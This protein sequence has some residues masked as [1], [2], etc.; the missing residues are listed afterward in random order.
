M[1]WYLLRAAACACAAGVAGLLVRHSLAP[2]FV[3]QSLRGSAV[4]VVAVTA[5]FAVVFLALASVARIASLNDF[6]ALRPRRAA[7]G[8][9]SS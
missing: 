2:Y 1:A 3:W 4:Y 6:A 5:V 8:R 9:A 7:T